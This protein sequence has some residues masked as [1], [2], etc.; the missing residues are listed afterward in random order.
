MVTEPHEAIINPVWA[1]S[2]SKPGTVTVLTATRSDLDR[3]RRKLGPV[4]GQSSDLFMSRMLVGCEKNAN[5]ALVGPLVGAPYAAM[6]LEVLVAGGARKIIFFGWCGAVSPRVKIGE[7]VIP[8][9]AMIDE[10][11]SRHYHADE[12]LLALPSAD[13]RQQIRGMFNKIE[14]PF[15]DGIVWTTDAVYRETREKVDRF[16]RQGL[17]AV[18]METSALFSVGRFRRV[19]VAAVLVVSDE[20]STFCW[21]PGFRSARF[22]KRLEDVAEAIILLSRNLDQSTD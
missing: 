14:I 10:G 9:A 13:L 7:I 19:D 4:R 3:L 22:R 17:L 15:H 11:T 21:K 2:A 1:N 5:V 6:V 16:Q 20:L 8:S 18:D 12:G